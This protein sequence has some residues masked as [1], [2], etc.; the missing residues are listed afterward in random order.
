MRTIGDVQSVKRDVGIKKDG[1][2]RTELSMQINARTK[3]D[4]REV[5][6]SWDNVQ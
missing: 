6:K 1:R 5:T 2:G 4:S 3:E